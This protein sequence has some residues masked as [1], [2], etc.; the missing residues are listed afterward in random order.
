MLPV[1]VARSS[2]DGIAIRYVLPDDVM[3]G[4]D[5]TPLFYITILATLCIKRLKWSGRGEGAPLVK[6][7][8]MRGMVW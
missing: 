3:Y 6:G 5:R 7:D 2:F 1:A 4:A 8:R